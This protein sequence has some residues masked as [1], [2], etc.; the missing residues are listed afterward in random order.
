VNDVQDLVI[1]EH[2]KM[3]PVVEV[4]C[5]VKNVVDMTVE[6][7]GQMEEIRIANLVDVLKCPKCPSTSSDSDE[8]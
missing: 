6:T 2:A 7:L 5:L 8:I 4:K 1:Q 3:V